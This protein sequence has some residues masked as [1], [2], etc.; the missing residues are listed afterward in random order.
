MGVATRCKL[1]G[2][3]CGWIHEI[4]PL[5]LTDLPPD[6]LEHYKGDP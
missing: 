1:Q 5:F 4:N 6:S 3:Q 2:G